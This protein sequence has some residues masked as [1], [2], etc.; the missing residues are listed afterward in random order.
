ML[1]NEVMLIFL[2]VGGT[3][4]RVLA[5]DSASGQST[6][7][8]RPAA[9]GVTAGQDGFAFESSNGDFRVAIASRCAMLS[10]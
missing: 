5:Q 2:L 8:E 10:K 4:E 9:A 7:V 6:V 3:A 1:R